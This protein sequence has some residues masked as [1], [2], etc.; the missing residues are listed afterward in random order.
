MKDLDY[1]N[2]YRMEYFGQFGDNKNGF[3]II[4]TKKVVFQVIASNGCDWEHVSVTLRNRWGKMLRRCPTW[5]E[6]C[7]I[8]S[9]FF[10]S[11]EVVMQLHP[12]EE[13]YVNNHPYCLHL[14]RPLTKEIPTPPSILVGFKTKK[15]IK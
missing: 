9:L 4:P 2:N 13:E 6:M 8:K 11:D 14:W 1:L 3:F 10:E 5:E 7:F 15:K 12:S